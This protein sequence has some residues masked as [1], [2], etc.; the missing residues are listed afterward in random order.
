MPPRLRESVEQEP[1]S[2]GVLHSGIQEAVRGRESLRFEP[3]SFIGPCSAPRIVDRLSAAKS[4]SRA[5]NSRVFTVGTLD[6]RRRAVSCALSSSRSR[7]VKTCLY[8]AGSSAT[9]P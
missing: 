6:W 9:A 4:M 1:S 7:R 2:L 3:A 8:F 5:R